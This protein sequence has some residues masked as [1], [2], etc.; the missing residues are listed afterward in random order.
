MQGFCCSVA[1]SCLTLCNPHGLQ[2]IRFPYPSLSPGVCSDMSIELMMSPNHLILCCPL[3][4]IPAVFPA[5]GN[6]LIRRD[7]RGCAFPPSHSV[8]L[9]LSFISLP[10][11]RGM[12][13][14]ALTY[15][16]GKG[17]SPAIILILDWEKIVF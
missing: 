10:A 1:Q 17:L 7:Q 16:S 8:S 2:H 6:V 4:L 13:R 15:K 9:S 12:G 14:K 11:M 5:S 3:L